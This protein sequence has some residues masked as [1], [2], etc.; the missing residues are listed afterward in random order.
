MIFD[1]K[2]Q[3]FEKDGSLFVDRCSLIVDRCSLFVVRCSSFYKSEIPLNVKSVIFHT[4]S[5]VAPI[6][7]GCVLF[8]DGHRVKLGTEIPQSSHV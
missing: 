4:L 2:R 8:G 1:V 5:S 3:V 7:L 6:S